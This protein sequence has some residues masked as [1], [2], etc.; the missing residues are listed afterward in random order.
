MLKRAGRQPAPR[1]GPRVPRI[2]TLTGFL[3]AMA[4]ASAE[5]GA[6][7][8]TEEAFTAG[9]PTVISATRLSQ[10]SSDTPASVTVIDRR[11]IEASGVIEIADLLRFVP[12]FQVAHARGNKFAVAYHGLADAWPRR[13]QVLVDGRS[14]YIP[15]ISNVDWSNLGVALEDIE[16]IEVIRGPNAVAYGANAFTAAINIVT[17]QPFEDPGAMVRGTVGAIDTRNALARVAG[18]SGA[19]DFRLTAGYRSDDGFDRV[20]D[21][22]RVRSL[23]FRG[24]YSPSY[25]DTV[26]VQLGYSGGS[27][28]TWGEPGDAGN[29][30]RDHPIDSHYGMVHWQRVLSPEERFHVQFYHNH[31]RTRDRYSI[32]L[33]SEYLGPGVSPNDIQNNFGHP[34]QAITFGQYDG[35]AE[36]YDLELEYIYTP[37]SRWR[38][39]TGGS[40]RLDR[41]RSRQLLD[42]DDFVEDRSRRAFVNAEWRARPATVV[43][44]GLMVERND[45]VG[46]HTSSRVGLNQHLT[47]GHTV[48]VS[49]SQTARTPSMYEN[50]VHNDAEF[51]DGADLAVTRTSLG[52]LDPERIRA[53]EL[54]Y[55]AEW[56]RLGVSLDLKAFRE[57]IR[58]II[59]SAHDE[60]YQQP[61][62]VLN[63][64]QDVLVYQNLGRADIEGVEGQLVFE[65][66][67]RDRL[68]IQYGYAEVSGQVKGQTHPTELRDL[69]DGVPRHTGSVLY[70]H[71]F[72]D[73][74]DGS[75][76]YY[77]MSE[78]KWLG[79][80]DELNSYSRLDVRLAQGL[81]PEGRTGEAELI[82]QNL[83][84]EYPEFTEDNR[85]GMRGY[86]RVT[87]RL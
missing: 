35:E 49:A 55:L 82:V 20:D 14:V 27:F 68:Q 1:R 30:V 58:D 77:S 76:A 18:S 16:R 46:R 7:M 24:D 74:L 87:L 61:F 42:R 54:G 66:G 10:S 48:R 31:Y 43:N 8:L 71:T 39:V 60:S 37:G 44:A 78:M 45:L 84:D 32:G 65:P 62:P 80:G 40:V 86:L 41:M 64:L 9:I 23:A 15:L 75:V 36:R 56:P 29:P 73:G 53:Y 50:F 2:G 12:G 19:L 79:D 5:E 3:G 6:G 52:D 67:P 4:G 83:L 81:G 17:R 47:P 33:L 57:E 72:P 85:F 25:R 59:R 38:V 69:G 63:D 28:G 26:G 22:K 34:D 51:D 21:R 70:R 11:T 13:L